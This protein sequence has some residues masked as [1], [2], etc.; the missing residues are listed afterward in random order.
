MAVA[1]VFNAAALV[2]DAG[3][4]IVAAVVVVV[5]V[6]A[7]NTTVHVSRVSVMIQSVFVLPHKRM[8]I[9]VLRDQFPTGV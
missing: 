4:V 5:V 6:V 9:V 8:S 1:A 3:V 7:V 2:T